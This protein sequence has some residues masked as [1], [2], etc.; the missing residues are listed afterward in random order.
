[1]FKQ[2]TRF[3]TNYFYDLIPYKHFIPWYNEFDLFDKVKYYF[4]KMKSSNIEER[5]KT[6]SYLSNVGLNGMKFILEKHNSQYMDCHAINML[7]LYSNTF[8]NI[9]I[10]KITLQNKIKYNE[11]NKQRFFD[12]QMNKTIVLNENAPNYRHKL[13]WPL[14]KAN[15]TVMELIE[16]MLVF[17]KL[18]KEDL[19]WLDY[20][21]WIKWQRKSIIGNE[22]EKANGKNNNNIFKE[23]IEL[24]ESTSNRNKSERMQEMSK[25]GLKWNDNIVEGWNA[26]N[27]ENDGSPFILANALFSV[28]A[29]SAGVCCRRQV[30][31]M[32]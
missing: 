16:S 18:R 6:I 19:E 14:H 5:E 25:N 3:K 24:S 15:K 26:Y 11:K 17:S 30:S 20:D 7:H 22:E 31:K 28:F 12:N 8:K 32:F 1:M 4:D 27:A 10:E 2:V 29:F 21:K 9:N 13:R 23:K